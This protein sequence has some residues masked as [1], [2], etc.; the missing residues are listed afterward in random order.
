VS[1]GVTNYVIFSVIYILLS[2]AIYLPYRCGQ[3]YLAPIY[4][5]AAGAYFS[6]YAATAWGW[7]TFLAILS[8]PVAGAI[9]AFIPALGLRQ[10]L[11]FT[12]AIASMALIVVS[13]TII[14]NLAFLGKSAGLFGIPHTEHMLP[15]ALLILVMAG[16][17]VHRID[18]SRFGRAAETLMIDPHLAAS[19]GINMSNISVFLQVASG[20]LS[21]LAGAIF[22]FTVGSLFPDAFGLHQLL[23]IFIIVFVGGTY[24]MWG[25]LIF[26]PILW[27]IPLILPESIAR[28]K[29]L[30]Y[31]GL[32]IA[33]LIARPE[34]VIGRPMIAGFRKYL[35]KLCGWTERAPVAKS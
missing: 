29:D 11:G 21:G 33:I 16:F 26:A 1:L 4:C 27:G 7:P 6:A 28:S 23:N 2:W 12:V 5:M 10:A 20:V 25:S 17:F 14:R 31:G 35:L 30:I 24:T 13:Q 18:Q 9:A 15:I 22:A 32:L 8:A 19:F 3:L 34:G